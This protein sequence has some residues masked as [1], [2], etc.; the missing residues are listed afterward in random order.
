MI[1]PAEM[2]LQD[3]ATIEKPPRGKKTWRE[4]RKNFPFSQNGVVLTNCYEWIIGCLIDW[5]LTYKNNNNNNNTTKNQRVVTNVLTLVALFK[6]QV[7]IILLDHKRFGYFWCFVYLKRSASRH[8]RAGIL[9]KKPFNTSESDR[10]Y[11]HFSMLCYLSVNMLLQLAS[12]PIVYVRYINI[13]RRLRG[14]QDK[15]LY[16]VVFSFHPS[17]FWELRDKRNLKILRFYLESLGAML[18]YRIYRTWPIVND[19]LILE[20]HN[21]TM[22]RFV[23]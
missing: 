6:N 11:S 18:E 7:K 12:S 5:W 8:K 21:V 23:S 10:G 1:F 15:R 2:S 16:L 19:Y 13:L 22:N 9:W 20:L 4:Q 17:L 14:F 3:W